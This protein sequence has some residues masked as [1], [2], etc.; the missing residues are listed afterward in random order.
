LAFDE[1][2]NFILKLHDLIRRKCSEKQVAPNLEITSRWFQ[3]TALEVF[4]PV[5]L[6]G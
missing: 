2:D 6:M 5:G 4:G 3:M 1:D